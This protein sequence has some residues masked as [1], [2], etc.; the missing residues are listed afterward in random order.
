MQLTD[1]QLVILSAA[2]QRDDRL[3]EPP[4]KLKGATAQ[5]VIG[6]L[7]EEGLLEETRARGS[8]PIWRRDDDGPKALRITKLGL[9]AIQLD[10]AAAADGDAD[11]AS[12]PTPAEDA[13]SPHRKK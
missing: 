1:T 4:A 12:V 10:D 9:K 7:L 8:M 2:S 11:V 13:A 5:K 3:V 6:K